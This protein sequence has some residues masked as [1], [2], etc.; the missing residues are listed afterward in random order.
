MFVTAM[1][2]VLATDANAQQPAPF[3]P[4][5]AGIELD[6]LSNKIAAE[7][8]EPGFLDEARSRAVAIAARAEQCYRQATADRERLVI[9][10]EPLRDIDA[11]VPPA[12]MDQRIEVR[13]LLDRAITRQTQCQAVKDQADALAA[14]ATDTQARISQQFLFHRV[15]SPLGQLQQLPQQL[16]TMP[17]RLRSAVDLNLKAGITPPTMLWLLL[18]SGI[19]AAGIGLYIRNRFTRWFEAGGGHDAD[20]QL[21]Y[22]LPKPIAEYSP[23]LLEGLALLGVLL[24]GIQNASLDLAVVRIAA[25]IFLYG[26]GC[27]VIDWATGPLSPSASIKGFIP[28]H[29]APM[30]RRLRFFIL[31]LVASFVVLGTDWLSIRLVDPSVGGRTAMTL[32]VAVSM[33][34]IIVYLRRVPGLM[35]RFRLIR[36]AGLL[37]LLTG[38]VCLGIGYENLAGYLIHGATRTALALLVLWLLLWMFYQAFDFLINTDTPAAV[39]VRRGLGVSR[40]G[41]RSGLGVL[42]LFADLILWLSFIVYLIYVWDE[43]GTTLD[44]LVNLIQQ[45]ETVGN[46]RIVPIDIIRGILVFAGLIVL[47]GW[48]KRW[49]QRRWLQHI[50]GDRGAREAVTTLI[51]YVGFLVAAVFGLVLAGID[52]SGLTI[53]GGAL[54]LGIGFGMQEIA[55]NFVS[56]IILLFERPIRAGDYVTVGDIEGFVRRIRLRATELETLNNQNVLV[57]NSELISGRVTN[58]VLRDPQGRLQ[59]FVRVAYGSDVQKVRQILER[60]ANEHSEVVTDGRAPAPRALLME[61]GESS[62]NFELRVRLHRI[63]RRYSVLSD[64]N[65]AIDQAFREEGIKVPYPQRDL[66]IVSYP[67]TTAKP[68]REEVAPVD[69]TIRTRIMH[70][71]EHVT[72]SHRRDVNLAIGIDEVW[73]AITDADKLKKWL[74]RD[75]EF[76]PFIG[77]PFSLTLRD[78]VQFNGRIDI[79]LPPRRMRLVHETAEGEEPLA[80]GPITTDLLLKE[81]EGSTQ[82]TVIVSGIPASEDWEIEYRRSE[83][84]WQDAFNELEDLLTPG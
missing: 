10:Y 19:L 6:D 81:S 8:F 2:G 66:H 3:D 35:H 27:V 31:T 65:F 50:V 32:L 52:L 76:R 20:P 83:D 57:P 13:A 7:A 71:P 54:A 30:R 62:L 74:A 60:V 40:E 49:I 5:A 51:G 23:M 33:I 29:V 41:S 70:H 16:A 64:L 82:L 67:D 14:E 78:D 4:I 43:A 75:G 72:R 73:H 56:G 36:Y 38:L 55:G 9:R 69:E 21:K 42:Q 24:T 59:V 58:W 77:G 1:A 11:E 53:I 34:I 26:L 39:S 63:E 61:F 84:R 25:G 80:S 44:E 22:L 68:A 15:A 79:F 12:V 48:I 45:G 46:I 47:I 18:G 28:D 37:T 17:P